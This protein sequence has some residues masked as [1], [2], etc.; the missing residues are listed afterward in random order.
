[1]PNE[2]KRLMGAVS[3]GYGLFQIAMSLLP[4]SLYKIVS[5]FGFEGDANTGLSCLQYTRNSEDMRAPF[6]T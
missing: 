5:F 2:I 4:P 3:F 1:M 6:S